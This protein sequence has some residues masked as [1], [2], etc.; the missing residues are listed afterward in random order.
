MAFIKLYLM[1]MQIGIETKIQLNNMLTLEYGINRVWQ[2]FSKRTI[3][4]IW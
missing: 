1:F 4:N 3:E 2:F